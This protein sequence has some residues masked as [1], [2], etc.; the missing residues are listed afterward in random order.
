[1][2]KD[3]TV[4]GNS[5]VVTY[6]LSGAGSAVGKASQAF[7][8]S[9]GQ[10]WLALSDPGLYQHGSIKADIEAETAKGYCAAAGR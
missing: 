2:I 3:V 8:Y 7:T 10:W 6:S 9:G 4:T 5:A 1:M